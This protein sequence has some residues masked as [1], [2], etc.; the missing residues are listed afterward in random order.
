MSSLRRLLAGLFLFCAICTGSPSL[1]AVRDVLYR[2]DGTPLTGVVVISWPAFTAADGT[3]IAANT[4]NIAVRNGSF[5]VNLV[6]TTNAQSAASYA[7][8]IVSDG[9]DQTR[10]TW[11]IPPSPLPLSIAAVL[12]ASSSG[13][14]IPPAGLSSSA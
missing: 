6:P 5:R 9:K 4:M 1:T 8:R 2:A 3:V 7:V 14:V 11:S 13:G 12:T 10:E